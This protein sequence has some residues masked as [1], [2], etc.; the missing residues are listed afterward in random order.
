MKLQTFVEIEALEPQ[1]EYGDGIVAI[2]SCFAQR[3]GS[4]L[5]RA[6]FRT[7]TNPT[8]VLFNPLSIASAVERFVEQ[9][10]VVAEQLHQGDMGWFHFDMHSSL[11]GATHDEAL[12]NINGAIDLAH[13][14]LVQSRWVVVTLGTAWVYELTGGHGAE[15]VANCHKQ[16]SKM[17]R[18]RRLSCSEVVEA[19][20]RIAQQLSDKQIILTLSPIRHLSDGA[21]DNA[22]SKA[23]LRLAIDEMVGKYK[24]IHYFPAYEIVLDELRD[25]RFY[26]EDMAHPSA[27][28]VEYIWERFCATALTPTTRTTLEQV[29]RIV[30]AAEHRPYN[31]QSEAHR[32]FCAAQ[33]RA[34]EQLPQVEFSKEYEYFSR[35]LKINS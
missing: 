15:V 34:I 8:G 3:I 4:A 5:E 26:D 23:T 30:R 14:S 7:T 12:S 2:G 25:Y 16:P 6:K 11:N 9:N 28:A 29:M 21:C 19:L 31:T 27:V 13:S 10:E 18:R 33:L 24:N 32:Q 17:F 35:N 22:V 1:I 20:E